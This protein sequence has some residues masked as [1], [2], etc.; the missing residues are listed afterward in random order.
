[1]RQEIKEQRLALISVVVRSRRASFSPYFDSK[2]GQARAEFSGRRTAKVTVYR[3][4]SKCRHLLGSRGG[5]A[6]TNTSVHVGQECP[7]H[8]KSRLKPAPQHG[9]VNSYRRKEWG[10]L[11]DRNLI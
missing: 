6:P 10:R 5:N 4:P 2:V 3:Q 8:R 9:T 7:T 1:M 11:V